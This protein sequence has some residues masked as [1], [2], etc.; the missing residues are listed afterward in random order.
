MARRCA[1]T[2]KGVLFG[3]NVSH[4]NNK[5]NRRFLPNLQNVSFLSEV[6][7]RTISLRLSTRAIRTVEFHGGL[8]A[9]LS[10]TP[11]RNLTAEILPLKKVIVKQLNA[12]K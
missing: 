12:K 8:D 5:S 6:L 11:N 7:G 2:G 4:A 10:S 1:L 9:Y 3:H